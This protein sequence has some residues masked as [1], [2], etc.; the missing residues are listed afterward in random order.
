[1][2]T[3]LLTLA[4]TLAT[5]CTPT[6]ADRTAFAAQQL[7]Y[8]AALNNCYTSSK[9]YQEYETCANK[10]DAQFGVRK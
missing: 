9:T 10:V 3:Y 6:T 7:S 8:G 5:G 2:R 1:M 4:L